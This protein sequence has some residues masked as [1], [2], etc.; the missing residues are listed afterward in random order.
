MMDKR[1]AYDIISFQ[2]NGHLVQ[3]DLNAGERLSA[4]LR[5][6]MHSRDVKIGCDAGD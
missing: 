6:K 1:T 4:T 3:T 2:L 5:D